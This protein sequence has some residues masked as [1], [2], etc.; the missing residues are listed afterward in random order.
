[1]FVLRRAVLYFARI[2]TPSPSFLLSTHHTTAIH[3]KHP[4]VPIE[5][6]NAMSRVPAPF[7]KQLAEEREIFN[8]LPQAVKQQVAVC[9]CVRACGCVLVGMCVVVWAAVVS[10][11]MSAGFVV[12]ELNR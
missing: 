9:V 2:H 8:E 10:T 4:Q 7:L 11:H 5:V 6:M 1:M 12:Q 3:T